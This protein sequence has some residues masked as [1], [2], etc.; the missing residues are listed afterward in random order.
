M[1]KT[2]SQDER[3]RHKR[4]RVRR[5]TSFVVNPYWPASGELL[6]ISEGGFAFRYESD[7]A[8]VMG[9]ENEAMLFGDHDSC[10]KGIPMTAV[11]DSVVGEAA[12]AHGDT[13]LVRRR[14]VKFGELSAK[15]RFL[16]ECF[17]WIN[18]APEC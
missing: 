18:A 16:L 3:R 12:H 10:L 13:R 8:W 11:T 15:Q 14:C 5:D 4:F 7:S 2:P 1:M 17:I 6:D 9:V